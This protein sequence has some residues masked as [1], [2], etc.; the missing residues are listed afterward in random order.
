[1]SWV[2]SYQYKLTNIIRLWRN[3]SCIDN[4]NYS[5]SIWNSK[6]ANF[7]RQRAF[8]ISNWKWLPNIIWIFRIQLNFIVA[9]DYTGS[10]GDP[11]DPKSL[12]NVDPGWDSESFDFTLN[13]SESN[14]ID[15]FESLKCIKI[16]STQM[17]SEL[18][19]TLFKNMIPINNF[20]HM[21][22]VQNYPMAKESFQRM[23]QSGR[24]VKLLLTV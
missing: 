2:Y 23:A 12:H 18:L 19:V 4:W 8:L 7:W 5:L 24:S 20:Q 6:L 11:R 14:F 3:N 16:I 17:L 13:R 9:I 15:D 1:M 10:N 22:L 21:V